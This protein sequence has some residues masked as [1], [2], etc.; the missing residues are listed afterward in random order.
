VGIGSKAGYLLGIDLGT[1]S[2][3]CVLMREDGCPTGISQR[4]YPI[5]SP[6]PGWGEQEPEVWWKATADAIGEVMRTSEV[7]PGSV[8]GVGLSGQMHGTVLIGRDHRPLRRSII[9]TDQRSIEQCRRIQEA[10]IGRNLIPIAANRV[11]AGFM[12]ASLLWIMENEP[13]IFRRAYK[14]LLPKD[15]IRLRLTGEIA[16]DVSDASGTLLFDIRNR[17]WSQ[18]LL[19]VAGI[20]EDILPVTLPSHEIAGRVSAQAAAETGLREGTP[21]VAGG[22]DQPV[23]AV[24]NGVVDAESLLITIGTGGQAFA[25]LSEMV[26]DPRLRTNTF[27]HSVPGLW[28]VMGAIL[29]AGFSLRWF[30]DRIAHIPYDEISEEAAEVP[31]GSEGLIFLPYLIGERTPHMDPHARG[32][33]L[34]L[35]PRHSL[36]HMARSIMEGVAFAVKDSMRVLEDLGVRSR[37]CLL[38][39]GGASSPLWRQIMA[40]VLNVELEITDVRE[41]AATG[42][43]ILAGIGTGIY[44]SFGEGCS[45]VLGVGETVRPIPENVEI[46]SRIYAIFRGLYPKLKLDFERMWKDNRKGGTR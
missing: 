12:A 43:A 32:A 3:K 7:D 21:V 18:E 37:R 10:L 31:P 39:G 15:Y 1:S 30:R 46:Y 23:A 36:P 11:A 13:H 9:W 4:E 44:S 14:A 24:G 45:R 19:S 42:A 20:P 25:P 6:R 26:Y 38:S 8:C 17:C 27:C 5:L 40:D 41:Q 34:G 22:G 29:S 2:L 33:F 16:S 28:F 35:T